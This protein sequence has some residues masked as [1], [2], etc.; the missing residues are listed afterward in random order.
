ME[1][2]FHLD[3]RNL[4][5][6]KVTE[7]EFS[8]NGTHI[9]TLPWDSNVNPKS[10]VLVDNDYNIAYNTDCVPGRLCHVPSQLFRDNIN[11]CVSATLQ[12]K[13]S[14]EEFVSQCPL[15]CKKT[16]SFLNSYPIVTP[17]SKN[18]FMFTGSQGQN[19]ADVDVIITCAGRPDSFV[20]SVPMGSLVIKLPCGCA[21]HYQGFD[22]SANGV[23]TATCSPREG[24]DNFTP[25]NLTHV[26]PVHWIQDQEILKNFTILELDLLEL[27]ATDDLL[28][29]GIANMTANVKEP[30]KFDADEETCKTS[31]KPDDAISSR[32]MGVIFGLCAILPT[33]LTIFL[34]YELRK[35]SEKVRLLNEP[36]QCQEF[37]TNGTH[38]VQG[39]NY[40]TTENE[41]EDAEYSSIF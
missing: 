31:G 41:Y 29:F 18:Q 6:M 22:Q 34:A 5:L 30:G 15:S 25:V 11:K 12:T 33:L 4:S 19:E 8:M 23:V 32:T 21:I 26:I 1:L 16:V 2:H 14:T 28:N 24:S 38:K 20:K 13:M 35:L 27:N 40:T 7:A 3:S 9:C 36:I 17:L 10:S 39:I 37:N